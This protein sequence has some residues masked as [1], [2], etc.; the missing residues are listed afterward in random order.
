M[1][2]GLSLW[3]GVLGGHALGEAFHPYRLEFLVGDAD[4]QSAENDLDQWTVSEVPVRCGCKCTVVRKFS[5]FSESEESSAWTQLIL[6]YT[7]R[8]GR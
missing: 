2:C 5:S 4:Q 3:A 7:G 8:E 6:K 1:A